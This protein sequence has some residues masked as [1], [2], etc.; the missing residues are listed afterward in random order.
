[1][2]SAAVHGKSCRSCQE[3]DKTIK[4]LEEKI[5]VVQR[6]FRGV[7]AAIKKNQLELQD[8]DKLINE[9]SKK[10]NTSNPEEQRRLI[11]LEST[12][13]EMSRTVGESEMQKLKDKQVIQSLTNELEELTQRLIALQCNEDSS[14]APVKLFRNREIQTDPESDDSLP[15]KKV[16]AETQTVLD[17]SEPQRSS[18]R[19]AELAIVIP[20]H[21]S[22]DIILDP[23]SLESPLINDFHPRPE[24]D[25]SESFINDFHP[26]PERDRTESIVSG[27][28]QSALVSEIERKEIELAEARLKSREVEVALREIEWKYK[29]ERLRLEAK[30]ANLERENQ[31]LLKDKTF[32][33]N[34]IYV[35]NVLAKL[36]K[37]ED[38]NQKRIM[39]NALLTALD[40]Q[41]RI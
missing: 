17:G 40:V 24:R 37:T 30:V 5:D 19:K 32:Q 1:M 14:S 22:P 11:Q 41:E 20:T 7:V 18:S 34:L 2:A 21:R 31:N 6:S 15:A 25:R 39:M 23:S 16:D 29:M 36:I 9:L 38:K 28:S 12:V 8:K 27:I 4:V 33:P 3:K 13:T 26:R 10:S 35:R